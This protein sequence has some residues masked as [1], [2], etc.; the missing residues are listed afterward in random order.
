ME[1]KKAYIIHDGSTEKTHI[2]RDV[3][4]YEGGR[5][6]PSKVHVTIPDPEESDEEIDVTVNA[7]PDLKV[8]W[9]YRSKILAENLSD[10]TSEDSSTELTVKEPGA[11]TFNTP[12]SVAVLNPLPPEVHR[13]ARLKH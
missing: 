5:V 9:N 13:Y 2:S 8:S 11:P 6:G 3:V 7:G 4:Y 1:S 10:T 12:I